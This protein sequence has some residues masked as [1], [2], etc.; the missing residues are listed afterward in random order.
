[1]LRWRALYKVQKNQ[2]SKAIRKPNKGRCSSTAVAFF[3]STKTRMN[4]TEQ[5]TAN[6]ILETPEIV[7]IKGKRYHVAPP[8]TATLIRISA[9]ISKM[10]KI[11]LEG[12]VLETTLANAQDCEVLGEIAAT[13]I[14]GQSKPEPETESVLKKIFKYKTQKQKLTESILHQLS[15]KELNVIIS[16]LL[17]RLEIADFFAITTSLI[18]INLIRATRGVEIKTIPSGH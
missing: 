3:N 5:N 12:N 1:M 7:N 2:L 14:C 16:N 11:K 13:L 4:T 18:D 17:S 6:A 15:P 8:T 10:P 9:L